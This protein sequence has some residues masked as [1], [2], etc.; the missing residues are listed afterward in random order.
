VLHGPGRLAVGAAA[1]PRPQNGE[2]LVR[3]RSVGICGTDVSIFSGRIPVAYPR[4]LGHEVVGELVEPGRSSLPGGATVIV[5]PGVA[6]GTCPQCREGRTNI[7]TRGGLLGRDADG[8]LCE[9]L[10]VPSSQL[11][12]VPASLDDVTAP[13]L[14]VLATCVHAQRRID[15]V[16]AERVVVLGLGVTGLLHLQLAARAGAVVVGVTRS[17]EKRTLASELG[18][19]LTVGADGDAGHA[20]SDAI[21]DVD[22][23]IECAGT[24]G[25]LA[26]SIELARVGGRILAYGTITDAEAPLP[27]YDLYH[28]EL[29]VVGARSAR[30][31]DFPAAVEAV[32]TGGVRLE[33]LISSSFGL[34]DVGDA[35]RAAASPGTLKTV[36]DV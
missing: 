36:V 3:V 25:T 31:E 21:G 34:D 2:A 4:V 7:C 35:L 17:A 28:K 33:R 23:V 9:L 27:Y 12:A 24:A 18:A 8:G 5:D 22:V 26:R 6:C 1:D 19:D 16:P 32:A 15:I 30:P 14:Q 20:I 11:H 13:M 29:S 10:T